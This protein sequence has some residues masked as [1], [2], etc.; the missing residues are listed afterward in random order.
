[1]RLES[2]Q[3]NQHASNPTFNKTCGNHLYFH[4]DTWVCS[5]IEEWHQYKLKSCIRIREDMHMLT[6]CKAS[7][8]TPTKSFEFKNMQSTMYSQLRSSQWNDQYD[9]SKH[10]PYDHLLGPYPKHFFL[11]TSNS[12]S[13]INYNSNDSLAIAH[14]MNH[15]CC[16]W[17]FPPS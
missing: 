8:N 1:M 3:C 5:D 4:H 12:S 13:V 2:H 11:N 15:K 17:H 16:V 14:P 10:W 6:S 9:A 7:S